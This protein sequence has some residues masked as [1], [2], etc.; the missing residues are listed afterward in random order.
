[1]TASSYSRALLA[2]LVI[3]ASSL[4]A[5][6]AIALHP[7]GEM[8]GVF[9]PA[10]C[11]GLVSSALAR[12]ATGVVVVASVS[13]PP[14]L[15]A[16][17]TWR[18]GRRR[19]SELELSIEAGPGRREEA[20]AGGP[21]YSVIPDPAPLAFTLGLRSPR[22]F[23]SSGAL[24]SLSDEELRAVLAHEEC[25][26]RAR[27]PLRKLLLTALRSALRYVPGAGN[28]IDGYLRWREYE[29][30][31]QAIRATGQVRPLQTAFLKLAGA[32]LVAWA[33]NFTDYAVSRVDR[34]SPG[35]GESPGRLAEIGR[36]LLVS[37][38]TFLTLPVLAL[39]VTEW[40]LLVG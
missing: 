35:A 34:L 40:H 20:I 12:S 32:P 8:W 19:T 5:A 30:D 24:Q 29:A 4:T 39:V 25:H 2:L 14:V 33:A 17:S 22:I 23:V 13:G 11:V 18:N 16:V 28:L 21:S 6:I 10:Q 1:M 37:S 3:A 38:S 7:L 27:D 31:E 9:S 26:V 15:F 36:S